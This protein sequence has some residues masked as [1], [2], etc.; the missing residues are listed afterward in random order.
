MPTIGKLYEKIT[1]ASNYERLFEV[2]TLDPV[3]KDR[4]ETTVT[5]KVLAKEPKAGSTINI[6]TI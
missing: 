5:K 4:L 2:R 6:A 3:I 1:N